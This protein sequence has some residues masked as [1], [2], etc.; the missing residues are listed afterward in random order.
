[1]QLFGLVNRLLASASESSKKN[2][3]VRTYSIT[4]LRDNCGIVSWVAGHDP[5]HA[6]IRTYRESKNIIGTPELTL[7]HMVYGLSL[8]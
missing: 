5:L 7:I 8:G 1:M 2:L 4:P 3:Y 6:L